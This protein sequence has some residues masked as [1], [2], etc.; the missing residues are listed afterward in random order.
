M[1][2]WV[3]AL[4]SQVVAE[5]EHVGEGRERPLSDHK[6]SA[7]EVATLVRESVPRDDPTQRHPKLAAQDL[8]EVAGVEEHPIEEQ[9][10]HV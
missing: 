2:S 5:G 9:Q 3:L 8:A 6:D 4:G 1:A 7:V 10:G